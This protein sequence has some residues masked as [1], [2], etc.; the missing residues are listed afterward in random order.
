MTFSPSIF[1]L[2]WHLAASVSWSARLALLMTGM[3]CMAATIGGLSPTHSTTDD[4]R[5]DIR[6]LPV[7][8]EAVDQGSD[9]A[10]YLA[11]F[12][13]YDV[14]LDSGVISVRLSARTTRT[15]GGH[16]RPTSHNTT[17]LKLSFHGTNKAIVPV[18]T[19][20]LRGKANYF[21]GN[22]P[23]KW[24]KGAP[25]Y[26]SVLYQDVYSGVDFVFQNNDG[27]LGY[28]I[29]LDHG[30]AV[31]EIALRFSGHDGI[32][33]NA[34]GEIEI[35]TAAGQATWTAPKAFWDTAEGLIRAEA[36]YAIRDDGSVGFEI[37]GPIRSDP[38]IIDPDLVFSTF[39]GGS[40]GDFINGLALAAN[41][42]I[43]V[44]GATNSLDFPRSADAAQSNNAGFLD[45]FV[46]MLRPDASEIVF[47]TYLGGQ[48]FDAA[49]GIVI[50]ADGSISTCGFTGST[51]FPTS[52]NAIQANNNA[53]PDAFVSQLSESGDTLRFSSYFGGSSDDNCTSM[54]ADRQNRLLIAGYTAS[55]DFPITPAAMSTQHQGGRSA[56]N[57]LEYDG[58]FSVLRLDQPGIEYSTFV[59]GS[60]SEL[61]AVRFVGPE[62]EGLAFELGP[63]LTTDEEGDVYLAGT[64][65]SADFPVPPGSILQSLRGSTSAFI[66]KLAAEDYS[67]VASTSLDG[68]KMDAALSIAIS[69]AGKVVVGG[70]TSSSDFPVSG[71]AFQPTFGGGQ[72]DG[73]F[74]VLD[75]NLQAVEYGTYIGGGGVDAFFANVAAEDRIHIGGI[76]SSI[77]LP[78]SPGAL[79]P[80]FAGVLDTYFLTFNLSTNSVEFSTYIGGSGQEVLS[81]PVTTSDGGVLLFG[82]SSSPGFTT[83]SGVIGENYSGG[84]SD[85]AIVKFA[86]GMT[87]GVTFV[88]VSSASFAAGQALA[89]D[90]IAAGFGPGLATGTA[91]ATQTPLPTELLGT[92]VE[93][94]DSEGT[95]RAAQLF[96]VSAGQINYLIPP[97]TALGL[98]TIRV[99]SG[100]G[101]EI[102]GTIQI[103]SVAPS[104]Y[105]ANSQGSGLAAAFFLRVNPDASRTQ[106]LLF[107]PATAGAVPINVSAESGQV[108]LLLF[109]TG[110]RG[111][112]NQVTATV[113]GQPVPVLGALPQGEF[114]GLD[115]IN[116]G[117]LPA[118]LV[119][120]GQVQIVL[121]VDGQAANFVTVTIQ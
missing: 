43:V 76:T 46:T 22:D 60:G 69:R 94:T 118:S 39:I 103:N 65:D 115:Q 59:G 119:G 74:V 80:G 17:T 67:L 101:G 24:T 4:E 89:A 9:S 61:Q 108:F 50:M 120:A 92:R 79:Q 104:L 112:R 102:E 3:S 52:L 109:G 113:G 54:V 37:E 33:L 45:I 62:V 41:G 23:K 25:L 64:T 48:N 63:W 20:K 58:F 121:I 78:S 11:R 95:T 90:V 15:P 82:G 51:D 14:A 2:L 97:G 55:T 110:F 88:S 29:E 72:N 36:T 83:T 10:R 93:V 35:S 13:N 34:H 42:N 57:P 70:I 16:N 47:S 111:F 86:G 18:G 68:D 26:G 116:I 75:S 38:L 77:D 105:S 12:P 7:A 30:D 107:D 40:L 85:G 81:R 28:R 106:G 84:E 99:I 1:R 53:L 21:I 96:F 8:F 19:N 87:S 91:V 117:P 98:A 27:R 44:T 6:Q 71:S 73:F 31:H 100:A 32:G 114:V 49:N 5:I 66:I 56:T